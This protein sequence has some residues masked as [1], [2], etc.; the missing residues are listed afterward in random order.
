MI[1][2][3]ILL[4]MNYK[5]NLTHLI[6]CMHINFYIF[7]NISFLKTMKYKTIDYFLKNTW[8][9]IARMYNEE[10]ANYGATMAIGYALL[11]IDKENGIAS[12]A[13]APLMGMEPTS[14]T[15]TLKSMEEKGLIERKKNPD[16]RRNVT[17]YLT[18]LGLEK[19][20]LSK[21]TVLGF[22]DLIKENIPSEQLQCFLDVTEKINELVT[23]K[24]TKQTI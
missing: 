13:L 21:K 2:E 5:I 15:R 23:N 17:I 14:L 16:N 6:I 12:T 8:Q 18:P 24:K 3:K 1:N 20:E 22:Q 11:N 4:Q 10:A 9:A 7:E 19:R